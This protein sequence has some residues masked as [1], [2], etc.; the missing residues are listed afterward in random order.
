MKPAD[1][2]TG[3]RIVIGNLESASIDYMIVGS[4]AGTIYGEPRLTHDLDL[5]ISMSS[6]SASNLLRAFDSNEF[7]LPPL[8]IISQEIVRGG[9]AN[10]LHHS[11]G[12]KVDIMFR[13]KT[14]HGMEEFSR[15]RRL[16][17]LRGLHAWV[18]APEDVIIAKLRYYRE[19]ESEKHLKDIRGILA[20]T[21]IHREYLDRWI[22]TLE[23]GNYFS[24]V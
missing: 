20:N 11:S 24:K 14:A 4:V 23:L 18:A 16:E 19:G 7:Y 5:V 22:S 1:I 13:K 6:S 21:E 10:L 15:R 3:L 17:I 9:Q 12:V 2:T 8:E